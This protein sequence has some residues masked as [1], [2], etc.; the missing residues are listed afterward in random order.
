MVIWRI[1]HLGATYFSFLRWENGSLSEERG[2]GFGKK[3]LTPGP[4]SGRTVVRKSSDGPSGFGN[5]LCSFDCP[6]TLGKSS[7][8]SKGTISQRG[9]DGLWVRVAMMNIRKLI[10]NW[11]IWTQCFMILDL[12]KW[13]FN[14]V[15]SKTST[16]SYGSLVTG[17]IT[18]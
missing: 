9:K 6:R 18:T 10:T 16:N 7:C 1:W 11:A 3:V 13:W 17:Q 2:K 5:W 14:R 4:F 12:K 8:S 15:Q